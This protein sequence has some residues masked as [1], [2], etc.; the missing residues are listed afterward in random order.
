MC[1]ESGGQTSDEAESG[2]A[3]DGQVLSHS[4]KDVQTLQD[5][6]ELAKEGLTLTQWNLDACHAQAAE[7]PGEFWQV[8][9]PG[10]S[11]LQLRRA[12]LGL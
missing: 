8:R 6:V 5:L 7:Q 9:E 10:P 2:P 4:Q 3:A 12:R 1:T 11:S